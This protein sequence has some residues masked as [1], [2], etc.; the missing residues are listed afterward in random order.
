MHGA[1]QQIKELPIDGTPLC[2]IAMARPQILEMPCTSD[3]PGPD[4]SAKT[5]GMRGV[6]PRPLF[7][8]SFWAI[9][10]AAAV[11]ALVVMALPFVAA[12]QIVRDRI[13]LEM[14]A[15]SGYNV[16]IGAPPEIEIWPSFRAI[17]TDVTFS[18]WN[19]TDKP[20][21][22]AGRMEIEL[23]ALS[24]LT[25]DVVF[26]SARLSQPT[27][28]V[29]RA[30]D[31]TFGPLLPS[32]GRFARS[33]EQA[34]SIVSANPAKP[35]VALL[36]TREFGKIELE[37]GRVVAFSPD[38]DEV[39][40]SDLAVKAEW[41]AL[42]KAG[43][44]AATGI[45]RGEHV[46]LEISSSSPLVLFAGGTAPLDATF[47]SAPVDASFNGTAR[48]SANAFLDGQAKVSAPSVKKLLEWSRPGELPESPI[49][50]IAFDSKVTG[51]IDRL[52]LENAL[53]K[54]DGNPGIGVLD[55]SLVDKV[56]TIAG[57]LAFETL[58]LGTFMS[59]FAPLSPESGT[60]AAEFGSGIANRINLDLRLSAAHATAGK[61]ALAEVAATAQVKGALAVFDISD[62]AAFGGN[63][64]AG[65]RFDRKPGGSNVEMRFLA[66]DIDG[67]EF[68]A[69]AGMHRIVPI[70]RGTVS[71]I[72][73]G[74]GTSWNSLLENGDGSLS[75][76][77][78]P[79]ALTD[80]DLPAFLRQ[81]A[82]GG[83]FPLDEVAKATLPIE[84]AELKATIA[85]GVA[86]IA[87][88]EA[89]SA[90][91][92]IWLTGIV[93]YVGRG[94]ALSGAVEPKQSA[95]GNANTVEAVPF[96]VG[97]SWNAP[98]VS[99]LAVPAPPETADPSAD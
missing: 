1:L 14:S 61:V 30:A 98:F 19:A 49:G 82:E 8:R 83:F 80:F 43:T 17:L 99:P 93:P 29:K 95:T 3:T 45:W 65:L 39:I 54:L 76:S 91:Y 13:A 26:T 21:V 58:D 34:R 47:R 59:A 74:Q 72:V 11:V 32:G 28:R 2:A 10:G 78:G 60:A 16:A 4:N 52:K 94:L 37:G 71:L 27:I 67:G 31:G 55:L 68:G 6:M 66:S 51:T 23:S 36:P 53:I 35:D 75:A 70:G 9:V 57:T 20:V 77:F 81:A 24:A 79:G 40:L 73:K 96:F 84:G 88:A 63:I 92:R 48:L 12:T 7:R 64:Q 62:A 97:G 42:N 90:T 46:A 22:E 69:A 25:G 44:F 86:R 56:P 87:K 41:A 85:H 15:W 33:V 50:T 38:D 89:R 5:G 18:E